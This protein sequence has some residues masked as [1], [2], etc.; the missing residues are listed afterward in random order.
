MLLSWPV[1]SFFLRMNQIASLPLLAAFKVSLM[2]FF[3]FNP[4]MALLTCSEISLGLIF[5]ITVESC[6]KGGF[7]I[8]FCFL[9]Y[10]YLTQNDIQKILS[11]E[12]VCV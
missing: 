2:V 8:L 11:E 9:S 4:M 3:F 5:Q 12:N 10:F 7:N 6:W 1:Q